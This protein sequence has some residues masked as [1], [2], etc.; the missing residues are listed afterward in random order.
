MEIGQII[1]HSLR[2]L[3]R[4]RDDWQSCGREPEKYRSKKLYEKMVAS[5]GIVRSVTVR[6]VLSPIIEIQWDDGTIS[7][8][9]S[10]DVS[11]V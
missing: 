9:T 6:L 7:T 4:Y 10:G 2:I 1:S 11:P 5:R 8:C 3:Q